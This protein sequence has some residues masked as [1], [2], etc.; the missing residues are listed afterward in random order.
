MSN[1]ELK[2]DANE[3]QFFQKELEYIKSQEY[4]TKYPELKYATL[5]PVDTSAGA[6]AR[7]IT[8]RMYNH[9]GVWKFI[10]NYA[11]DLPR[12]DVQGKEFT[13]PVKDIGSSYG[14]SVMDIKA[15][16]RA[17]KRLDNKKAMALQK[18]Y[19]QKLNKTA[20]L[21]RGTSADG[22]LTGLIYNP[23]ITKVGA[24]TGDWA[25]ATTDEI[26]GDINFA[27]QNPTTLSK[28]VE[29][30]DTCLLP[31]A[32]YQY[33]ASTPRS[34]TSDTTILQFVKNNHP[35]VTFDFLNELTGLNPKPSDGTASAVDAILTYKRDPMILQFQVP[36]PKENLPPE[37][38]NL[39]FIVNSVASVSNVLVYYPIAVQVTEGI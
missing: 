31:L 15:S 34:A 21:A 37:A 29:S 26:I 36:M 30:V 6:G 22:G 16:K 25:T 28:G 39:E 9:T 12:A 20:W 10:A 24:P 38:R 3:T 18:T 8:Y 33:I 32:K 5:I 11:D 27:I 17:N 1:N 14:Y 23:N 35:G 13:A 19:E 4:E 7:S 2:L